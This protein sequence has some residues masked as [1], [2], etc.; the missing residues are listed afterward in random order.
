M[1]EGEIREPNLLDKAF[2]RAISALDPLDYR[3][4]S[5]QA[6]AGARKSVNSYIAGTGRIEAGIGFSFLNLF[7]GASEKAEDGKNEEV[8]IQF[9]LKPPKEGAGNGFDILRDRWNRFLQGKEVPEYLK[10]VRENLENLEINPAE[11]KYGIISA[12]S[13]FQAHKEFITALKVALDSSIKSGLSEEDIIFLS[14]TT[15]GYGPRTKQILSFIPEKV[16]ASIFDKVSTYYALNGRLE[17]GLDEAIELHSQLS[18]YSFYVRLAKAVSRLEKE[19]GDAFFIPLLKT[20]EVKDKDVKKYALLV[21]KYETYLEGIKRAV[22]VMPRDKNNKDYHNTII[23]ILEG[24][25]EPRDINGIILSNLSDEQKASVLRALKVLYLDATPIS[26]EDLEKAFQALFKFTVT[27]ELLYNLAE[28]LGKFRVHSINGKDGEI[29][30]YIQ[31]VFVRFSPGSGQFKIGSSFEGSIYMLLAGLTKASVMGLDLSS[32]ISSIDRLNIMDL[33]RVCRWVENYGLE[34]SREEIKENS[35]E[36]LGKLRL[37]GSMNLTEKNYQARKREVKLVEEKAGK[38]EKE[39][40]ELER[41][42]EA[43]RAEKKA[44]LFGPDDIIA[45]KRRASR[46]TILS[47]KLTRKKKALSVLTHLLEKVSSKAEDER[48]LRLTEVA[49]DFVSNSYSGEIPCMDELH[50]FAALAE[51]EVSMN[52]SDWHLDIVGAVAGKQAELIDF[53][54]KSAISEAINWE[55]EIPRRIGGCGITE[56]EKERIEKEIIEGIEEEGIKRFHRAKEYWEDN[57]KARL[58]SYLDLAEIYRSVK[59]YKEYK[60]VKLLEV[61]I[62]QD[63]YTSLA[64]LVNTVKAF[65]LVGDPDDPDDKGYIPWIKKQVGERFPS[66]ARIMPYSAM[67][68]EEVFFHE[69]AR[70]NLDLMWRGKLTL[71]QSPEA[72][73]KFVQGLSQNLKALFA[74]IDI[75]ELSNS[76]LMFE[77]G[78]M[79]ALAGI[80]LSTQLT[81]QVAAI[82]EASGWSAISTGTLVGRLASIG[83]WTT[84]FSTDVLGFSTGMTLAMSP[85][86]GFS[87]E[88][89]L[90][91]IKWSFV[92]FGGLRV[93]GKL[94]KMAYGFRNGVKIADDGIE[95]FGSEARYAKALEKGAGRDL[96]AIQESIG[97]AGSRAG[98]A[99][100]ATHFLAM[101]AYLGGADQLISLTPLVTKGLLNPVQDDGTSFMERWM[102]S[103]LSLSIIILGG[104]VIRPNTYLLER[105]S[106]N[107][108]LVAM[109]KHAAELRRKNGEEHA[110]FAKTLNIL[111]SHSR[112]KPEAVS[113]R[114]DVLKA[115]L[116]GALAEQEMNSRLFKGYIESLERPADN[117]KEAKMAEETLRYFLEMS[118]NAKENLGEI[119]GAIDSLKVLL[120]VY[121]LGNDRVIKAGEELG[122]E[123]RI[124]LFESAA[125]FNELYG[126]IFTLVPVQHN[127]RIIGFQVEDARPHKGEI[128]PLDLIFFDSNADAWWSGIKGEG[129][130]TGTPDAAPESNRIGM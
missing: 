105:V 68:A 97:Y 15:N 121:P 52:R 56:T 58:P 104:R 75:D 112:N 41:D 99:Q 51:V 19:F 36:W 21:A 79:G 35:S 11:D 84:T 80:W 29:Q 23:A 120:D 103:M 76:I 128:G 39:V 25:E 10:K 123:R 109:F 130:K 113:E 18:K 28:K 3:G 122:V 4:E 101:T 83:L 85:M 22:K 12:T 129:G 57:G 47:N 77:M 2:F 81:A 34:I 124:F 93:I 6:R 46:E 5:A 78:V 49:L 43:I 117:E 127:E 27:S 95:L 91:E 62:E 66:G 100:E 115:Y 37:A 9:I 110:G 8:N 53:N 24:R 92:I 14:S 42:I 20:K 102:H 7:G 126:D 32:V 96:R 87:P 60:A 67:Y 40:A 107:R 72:V 54:I 31:K 50:Q 114:I 111:Q 94:S 45:G 13:L 108:Q 116:D 89:Y 44:D 61:A 55:L 88:E 17:I 86:M 48:I 59:T 65:W 73:G 82:A 70:D 74:V 125:A 118:E 69:W 64:N 63:K 16:R 33:D 26:L 119:V 1:G 90:E 71:P 30:R 38:I 106:K 98:L